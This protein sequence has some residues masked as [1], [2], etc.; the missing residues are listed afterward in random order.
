MNTTISNQYL[1]AQFNQKGAEL[2][3]LKSNKREF[4]WDGD[5]AFWGKHS[6]VLFPIVGTLKNNQFLHNHRFYH[7]TRHGF[8]RDLDFEIVEKKDDEI[9]FK[10]IYTHETLQFYPFRFVFF[11]IYKLQ[12]NQLI[13]TF[14]VNNLDV[15]DLPFSV[16][17]HPAF[18]LPSQFNHYDLIFEVNEILESY[19]L[20]NDLISNQTKPIFL[21]ENAQLSLNY[22]MFKDDALIF[23]RLKSKKITILENKI[24]LLSVAFN[25]FP[26]LGLWTKMNAPFICIEPW[27]GYS[28]TENSNG[29]LFEKEGICILKPKEVKELN[30][31]IEILQNF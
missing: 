6:P 30:Y 27:L 20:H 16:G 23:K 31:S 19:Q 8:A 5:P 29:D 12:N 15:V 4:I 3:S 26:H 17:A 18:A 14:R 10:F 1:T 22:E 24:P 21:D 9:V 28:D 13:T 25:D 7:L 2:V 11:I